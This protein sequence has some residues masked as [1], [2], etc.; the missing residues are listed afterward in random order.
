MEHARHEPWQRWLTRLGSTRPAGLR[1]RP[2]FLSAV[3]TAVPWLAAGA[4]I[5]CAAGLFLG[6]GAAPSSPRTG[7]LYRI[8]FIHAPSA[9]VAM[10]LFVLMAAWA[11]IGIV[12]RKP[13][14]AMV[15]QAIAPTG[16]IF[17]LIAIWTG[18][19]WGR[20]SWRTWWDVEL[21]V[22]MSLLMIFV[23]IVLFRIAI[24]S[25]RWADRIVA[26]IAVAGFASIPLVPGPWA[27]WPSIRHFLATETTGPGTMTTAAVALLAI[28]VGLWLY[29]T[30]VVLLRLRCVILER[31]R[32]CEWVERH[33]G[34]PG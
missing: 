16:A 18:S 31:E 15:A 13:L 23:A 32:E 17:A 12:L 6:F 33:T 28:S 27:H 11:G 19:L 10:A 14:F 24:E 2:D 5:C 9:W 26:T 25:V 8:V 20:Q 21:A 4:V 29:S 7:S 34:G 1:S 30:A 3:G 22:E